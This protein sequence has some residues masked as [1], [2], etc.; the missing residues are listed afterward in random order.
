MYIYDIYF[1]ELAY[2]IVEAGKFQFCRAGQNAGDS[3]K[4]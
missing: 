1:K 2:M 4:N 3:G